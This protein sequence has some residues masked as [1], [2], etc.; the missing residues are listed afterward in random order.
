LWVGGGAAALTGPARRLLTM[1][2]DACAGGPGLRGAAPLPAGTR[3]LAAVSGGPDST[4]LLLWLREEGVDIAAAHYD[5]ALRP[6]SERDAAH[7]AELCARLGVPL[8]SE[9]RSEPLVSGSVQAAARALRYAFLHR[10]LVATGRDV[11]CMGH[12]ADDVVEG[13][14]MHLLRGS[15]LAGLRGM[16]ARRGPF[17]RPLLDVWRADVQAYLAAHG[18]TAL[19]DP[20]NADT[21]RY[22]RARVR[23]LLLPALERDRPGIGGRLRAAAAAAAVL[24]DRL[25][26]EA[27]LLVERGTLR[28]DLRRAPRATRLETYRQLYGRLPG[29]DRRQLEAMDRL[30]VHGPTGAGLDLPGRLRLRVQRNR[31]SIDVGTLPPPPPA[32]RI[33]VRSCAGCADARA[34]H[35]RPG[36]ALTVG[37]RRPGLRMR[38]VGAPG[39]RKLQDILT[40]AGVPRHLRDHLP[41]VFADGRLAWVPGI[42][43]DVDAAAPA[44]THAWHVSL[45][46]H[47]ETQVVL[48][49]SA[50]PRSPFI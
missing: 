13:A 29:L 43:L 44:G 26:A 7:V 28:A 34:A 12:T 9:R 30:A 46:G 47:P 14:V 27:A 33:Q 39:S 20:A 31:V 50:H 45:E 32:P 1:R 24:Q 2:G 17:V 4:A 48:S 42:A 21:A 25:E 38:P 41:L 37:Y 23:H 8:L 18:V 19:G 35:L 15:G 36:P 3:V 6:G 5:H 40:D 11:V 16:P 49:G 10:A 22:A